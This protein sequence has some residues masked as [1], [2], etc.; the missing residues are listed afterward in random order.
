MNSADADANIGK[1]QEVLVRDFPGRRSEIQD[2]LSILGGPYDFFPPLLVHGA[3]ST[4][5]TSVVKEI[6]R[7]LRRPYAYASCRSCHAA[8]ILFESIINSL[9]GHVRS[10]ENGYSSARKC[11]RA[12]D[13]V[14]FLPDACEEAIRRSNNESC[15]SP[16]NGKASSD[17]LVTVFGNLSW[18][19]RE[20]GVV[21]LIIDNIDLVRN[22]SGGQNL[23][24]VLFRLPELS[25]LPQLG[26]VFISSVGPHAFTSGTG[27]RQP[28]PVYFRDYLDDELF[29]IL[30]KKQI[31]SDLYVSFLNAVL[32]PFSRATRRITELMMLLE[33]LFE[34]YCAPVVSGAVLP[35]EQGKRKLFT[36][37]KP[38][39]RSFLGRA[40]SILAASPGKLLESQGGGRSV[41]SAP[42]S[43]DQL[44]DLQLPLCSKYLLLA[45]YI[46]STNPATLD[47][48][49]FDAGNA[50]GSRKRRRRSS[51]SATEKKENKEM[52]RQLK[53]PGS[54]SLE[55]LLAIF[56]CIA[57]GPG[58]K[59]GISAH[60]NKLDEDAGME[61]TSDVLMQLSTLVGVGL[62]SQGLT[63]PL[64]GSPK[65]RCNVEEEAIHMIARSTSF[66]LAKYLYYNC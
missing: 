19:K 43:D 29:Q 36:L 22:W 64:E 62:I 3:A 2:L 63:D 1:R 56:S 51:L 39:V 42:A 32:K 40:S 12:S 59:L 21:Y 38:H 28:L 5:K 20:T 41:I 8:R 4:G 11:E 66:P 45:A 27:C 25:R 55:R 50:S 16:S 61:V 47:A 48:A 54:F 53:G 52:E 57:T 31:K 37:I 23:L 10:A 60:D 35:D 17:E 18:F 13:F 65:F 14:E 26:M 7:H 15:S 33:P 9:V 30:V 34:Q 24:S 58:L 44:C 6:F 46:A 49:L